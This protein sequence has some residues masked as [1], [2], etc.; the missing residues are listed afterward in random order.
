MEIPKAFFLAFLATGYYS[1]IVDEPSLKIISCSHYQKKFIQRK[2]V[3]SIRVS[4]LCAS[5]N[6]TYPN[7]CVY[8]FAN[9]ALNLTLQIKFSGRCPKPH[10]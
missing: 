9:I 5:N 10:S 2:H 7:S 4:P 1:D 8:C 6:V 3:C